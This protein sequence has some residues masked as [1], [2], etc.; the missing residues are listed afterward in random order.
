MSE[1]PQ[2]KGQAK[3]KKKKKDNNNI[4]IFIEREHIFFVTLSITDAAFAATLAQQEEFSVFYI[5]CFY[6]LVFSYLFFIRSSILC[7]PSECSFHSFMCFP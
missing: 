7:Y 5:D 3:G 1:I 4:Y 6:S 2:K